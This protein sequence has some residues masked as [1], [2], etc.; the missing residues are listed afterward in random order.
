VSGLWTRRKLGGTAH[1]EGAARGL[2]VR[3]PCGEM[4]HAMELS[5]H[6]FQGSGEYLLAL[7][8][9]LGRARKALPARGA[10][11]ARLTTLR[12]GQC[13]LFVAHVAQALTQSLELIDPGLV[14]LGMMAA[15]DHL[16]LVIAED[17]ALELAGYGHELPSWLADPCFAERAAVAVSAQGYSQFRL[18]MTAAAAVATAPI[19]ESHFRMLS[20]FYLVRAKGTQ[21]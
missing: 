19:T 13:A 10:L 11:A 7:Q 8:R 3:R 16:V 9:M 14:N 4:L 15:Q 17:A 12:V 1:G 21:M 20:T 6:P 18:M 5:V 2:H